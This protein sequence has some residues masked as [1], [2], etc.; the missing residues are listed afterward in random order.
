M[1]H[2]YEKNF[3]LLLRYTTHP[4]LCLYSSKICGRNEMLPPNTWQ[5]C[6]I[7]ITLTCRGENI[8]LL[9]ILIMARQ[10]LPFFSRNLLF[11]LHVFFFFRFP[12]HR[13]FF[14]FF[15]SCFS[16]PSSLSFCCWYMYK[17]RWSSWEEII[18]LTIPPPVLFCYQQIISWPILCLESNVTGSRFMKILQK[19]A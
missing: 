14:I 4:F 3:F 2:L 16:L 17:V 12:L 6:L 1:T 7:T 10:Y 5:T 18:V 9:S 13:L 19:F 15:F 11:L 8:S